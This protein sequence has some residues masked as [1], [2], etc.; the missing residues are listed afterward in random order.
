MA[1]NI[2]YFTAF[3]KKDGK[4][5]FYVCYGQVVKFPDK[6][7]KQIFKIRIEG[8]GLNPVGEKTETFSQA[9]LI[10]KIITKKLTDLQSELP[11][12]MAPKGWIQIT[13]T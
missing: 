1:N 13:R 8:V 12:F 3:L 7:E 9:T 6:K 10:G 2:K 11:A 4:E 5:V